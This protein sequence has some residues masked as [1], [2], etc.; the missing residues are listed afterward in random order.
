MSIAAALVEATHHSAPRSGWPGTHDAPRGQETTSVREDP[1]LF[2]LAG[3]ARSCV[4]AARVA[5]TESAHTVCPTVV[6]ATAE[7]WKCG[8]C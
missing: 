6:R 4:R 7:Q 5:A 2:T 3:Q 1:E 8:S